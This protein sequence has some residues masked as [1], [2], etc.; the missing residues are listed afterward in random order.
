ME[1][2]KASEIVKINLAPETEAEDVKQC[3][4]MIVQSYKNSI[5]FMRGF[6]IDTAHFGKPMTGDENDVVDELYNQLEEYE[7]RLS[8]TDVV[9]DE[10][11]ENGQTD[12]TLPYELLSE[13]EE[14]DE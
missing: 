8:L 5:P 9:F 7:P 6:G 2:I 4:A 13:T 11:T 3:A 14:D 1:S 12:F 10:D